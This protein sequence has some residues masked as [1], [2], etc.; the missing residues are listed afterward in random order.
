M[1]RKP[2]GYQGCDDDKKANISKAAVQCFE[3][4]DQHLAGLL[5]VLVFL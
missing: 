4:R 5:A 1:E 2:G 3:M